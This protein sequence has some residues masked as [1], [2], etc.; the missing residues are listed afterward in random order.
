MKTTQNNIKD[1]I[2]ELGC[3]FIKGDYV[4]RSSTLTYKCFCGAV[5]EKTFE[6]FKKHPRCTECSKKQTKE[7]AKKNKK[8]KS[9]VKKINKNSIEYISQQVQNKQCKLLSSEYKNKF[10]IIRV[11]CSCEE[12]FE[13]SYI[14]FSRYPRCKKCS[15]NMT[16]E[17]NLQKY[18][19]ENPFGNQDIQDKIKNTNLEKYGTENPGGLSM[20]QDKIKITNLE[21]Y[22]VEYPSQ[23][24]EIRSKMKE[25]NLERYGTENPFG[26]QDIK[27]KIKNTNIERYGVEYPFGNQDIK[28]KIKNTNLQKYG[29][30]YPSQ[31]EEIRKKSI[32]TNIER[33]GVEN[34]MQSIEV[35]SKAKHY[36]SKEYE[37]PSGK[38]AKYQGYENFALDVLLEKY[39]EED[40]IYET[41]LIPRISYNCLNKQRYYFPDIFIPK[42]NLIIEVKSL[43]IYKI[44]L[45]VNIH[46]A[47]ASRKA[48][49]NFEFWIFDSKRNLTIL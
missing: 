4:N 9:V 40:I 26:N 28:D 38:I 1:K 41:K 16:N 22:G 18:G 8:I 46:K 2:K 13:K 37:L 7:T 24:E 35:Q 11:Q 5:F 47:L 45:I 34:P 43:W 32:E 21:K 30:E 42:E 49:Y 29:V 44:S 10:S 33:Y 25:T 39:N 31:N 12:I 3:L 23:N 14:L 48:G 19:T 17:T 6:T 20:I 27:D 15:N 36:R